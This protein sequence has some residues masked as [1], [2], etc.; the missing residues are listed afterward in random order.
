MPAIEDLELLTFEAP[1]RDAIHFDTSG[2]PTAPA[3]TASVCQLRRDRS[4]TATRH[5]IGHQCNIFLDW[6]T[7]F[8][9]D[10]LAVVIIHSVT[11]CVGLWQR[12]LAPSP[13][14]GTQSAIKCKACS[15]RCHK[16]RE[17]KWTRNLIQSQRS[18]LSY[19]HQCVRRNSHGQCCPGTI[20]DG[21]RSDDCTEDRLGAGGVMQMS[22]AS[23]AGVGPLSP[24]LTCRHW[25]PMSLTSPWCSIWTSLGQ[26]PR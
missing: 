2:G 16:P 12:I 23:R 21:T 5:C 7:T 20:P 25:L 6:A 3:Q 26:M 22:G 14:C 1:G 19:S 8:F 4:Q 15:W 18:S 13:C 24:P 11:F 17:N 10:L 9:L